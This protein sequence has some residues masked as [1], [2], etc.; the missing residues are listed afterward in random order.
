MWGDVLGGLE[1]SLCKM[2]LAWPWV[3]AVGM[4][5]VGPNVV[6]GKIPQDSVIQW[7]GDS[8]GGGQ[9]EGDV[10]GLLCRFQ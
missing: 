9:G 7:L 6:L 5:R 1:P 10:T 8:M 2:S 3:P 4:G